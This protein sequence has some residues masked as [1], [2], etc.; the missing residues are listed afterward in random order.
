MQ[1][2]WAL[3]VIAVLK[4][5]FYPQLTCQHNLWG[6]VDIEEGMEYNAEDDLLHYVI[7]EK[8]TKGPQILKRGVEKIYDSRQMRRW[9]ETN[10][11]HAR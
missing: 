10:N 1:T 8:K 3:L 6:D 4:T 5:V 7:S 9:D 2:L 11:Y